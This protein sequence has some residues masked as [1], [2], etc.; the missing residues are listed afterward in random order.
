MGTTPHAREPPPRR[1]L[2]T[3]RS[4]RHFS[5]SGRVGPDLRVGGRRRDRQRL[6][7]AGDMSEAR[8]ARGA[9]ARPPAFQ[10]VHTTKSPSK[11]NMATPST[12]TGAGVRP[13]GEV[14]SAAA[15][16]VTIAVGAR[17]R[18]TMPSSWRHV[19]AAQIAARTKTSKK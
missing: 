3:A 19:P 1:P 7:G 16:N 18:R 13:Y 8:R 15:L 4:H 9:E 2:K 17:S 11:T 10:I 12:R 5:N 6:G 14:I